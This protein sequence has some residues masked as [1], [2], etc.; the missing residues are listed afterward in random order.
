MRK[1]MRNLKGKK[2]KR[3]IQTIMPLVELYRYDSTGIALVEDG[4]TGN[5][6]TCHP[7][8]D[9]TGSVRGIK[10]SRAWRKNDRVVRCG[11]CI[12]N[13]DKFSVSDELDQI[14]AN[15]CRCKACIGNI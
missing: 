3:H 13:I 1:R 11:G 2:M 7:S 4:T 5:G 15:S 12:Y 9:S 14:A 6:H 10:Q 8:I